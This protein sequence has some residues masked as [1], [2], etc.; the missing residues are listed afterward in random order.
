LGRSTA[1]D[2]GKALVIHLS[3]NNSGVNFIKLFFITDALKKSGAMFE[4]H[5]NYVQS[6]F[7]STAGMGEIEIL[8]LSI[9]FMHSSIL[10]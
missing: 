9:L 5:K 6:S 2:A 3:G 1:V 4:L 10:V 8:A 7:N